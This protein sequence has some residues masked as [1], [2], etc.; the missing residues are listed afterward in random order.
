MSFLFS[1]KLFIYLKAFL[2]KQKK[3]NGNCIWN[4]FLKLSI[5]SNLFYSLT[6]QKIVCLKCEFVSLKYD[7]PINSISVPIKNLKNSKKD[8]NVSFRNIIIIL[9]KIN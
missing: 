6:Y 8:S 5:V 2:I 4:D 1:F 3:E 7:P 9:K